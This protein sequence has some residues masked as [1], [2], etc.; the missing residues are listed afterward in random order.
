MTLRKIHDYIQMGFN[1]PSSTAGFRELF[2]SSGTAPRDTFRAGRRQTTMPFPATF[3]LL[4]PVNENAEFA[5]LRVLMHEAVM[6]VEGMLAFVKGSLLAH[7]LVP[8]DR[9]FSECAMLGATRRSHEAA[10]AMYAIE[11]LRDRP[12]ASR[13]GV[14][15][16]GSCLSPAKLAD[17]LHALYFVPEPQ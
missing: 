9:W 1:L 7:D 16:G 15:R 5:E 13:I 14:Y 2:V 6:R 3:V 10:V 8:Y 17:V 11:A 4:P 12:P